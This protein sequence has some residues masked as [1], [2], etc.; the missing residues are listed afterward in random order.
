M[1]ETSYMNDN[2]ARIRR[3]QVGIYLEPAAVDV[4]HCVEGGDGGGSE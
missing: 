3:H 1:N 4:G 2:N